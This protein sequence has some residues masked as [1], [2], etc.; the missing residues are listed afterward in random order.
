VHRPLHCQHGISLP[1]T[2]DE[3]WK[4]GVKLTLTYTCSKR[5]TDNY[6][7]PTAEPT[8]NRRREGGA[9]HD[10]NKKGTNQPLHSSGFSHKSSSD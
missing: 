1:F 2:R 10:D 3:K 5:E 8:A 6:T 9:G 7:S 4:I